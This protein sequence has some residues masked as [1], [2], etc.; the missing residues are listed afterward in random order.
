MKENKVKGGYCFIPQ[1]IY[2]PVTYIFKDYKVNYTVQEKKKPSSK[3]LWQSYA[4]I[5][6]LTFPATNPAE[7]EM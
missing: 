5:F 1:R 7:K 6:G 3:T 4:T 2:S